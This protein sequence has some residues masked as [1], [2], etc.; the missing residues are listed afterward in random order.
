MIFTLNTLN[1]QAVLIA[2]VRKNTENSVLPNVHDGQVSVFA[3]SLIWICI[4]SIFKCIMW[5]LVGASYR[6]QASGTEAVTGQGI[7]VNALQLKENTW[8]G[9]FVKGTEHCG[10][11]YKP[12]INDICITLPIPVVKRAPINWLRKYNYRRKMFLLSD[13]HLNVLIALWRL[14]L[15]SAI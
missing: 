15:H 10:N 1:L 8:G 4:Q 3:I 7:S 9:G 2:C 12:Y 6:T 11:D 5:A 14:M 13:S